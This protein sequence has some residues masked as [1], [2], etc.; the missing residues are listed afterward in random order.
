MSSW[1]GFLRRWV[2]RDAP[3]WVELFSAARPASVS[4]V[5]VSPDAC[6]ADKSSPTPPPPHPPAPT[7]VV[8]QPRASL[9][10][11]D[12][13]DD[14]VVVIADADVET[15]NEAATEGMSPASADSKLTGTAG[16]PVD[17]G[18]E[19]SGRM[20]CA[21]CMR[22]VVPFPAATEEHTQPGESLLLGLVLDGGIATCRSLAAF[23]CG[24]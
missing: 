11:R 10:G 6:G 14:G 7:V 21:L 17:T 12:A 19:W 8:V 20:P 3:G 5:N 22:R 1:A 16:A 18:G 4:P 9:H 15:G 13:R 24:Q 2:V 23:D